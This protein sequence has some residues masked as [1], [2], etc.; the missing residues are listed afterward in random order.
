MMAT[1]TVVASGELGIV[2]FFKA[3]ADDSRLRIVRMLMLTDLRV[4]E[5]VARIGLP[6]NATSYHLKQLRAAGILRD[7]RGS[8]DARDIYYSIDLDHLYALYTEAGDALRPDHLPTGTP[9]NPEGR[10]LDRPL[11]VLFL[12]THNSARS[13]LAEG[14]LRQAAGDRVEVWSAGSDPRRVHPETIALLEEWNID[15]SQ[16]TSKPISQFL[17]QEFDY[18]ITV[19]D[20]TREECPTFPGDPRQ[21]H[22]SLPDPLADDDPIKRRRVFLRVRQELQTRIQYLMLVPEPTSRL[23]P[24]RPDSRDA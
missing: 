1:G 24:R 20:R 19:C 18:I 22:W 5:I 21:L 15:A 12:C 8:A 16:H 11:R 23:R 2:R 10:F 4:G 3:L 9:R 7:R 17:D 14:I 6:A 13:Q